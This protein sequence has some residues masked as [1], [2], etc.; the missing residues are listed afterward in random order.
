M[1]RLTLLLL[2]AAL[3]SHAH[4]ERDVGISPWGATDEIGQLNT[5][6]ARQRAA[7][8][9]RLTSQRIYD[10]SVDYYIGMPSWQAAGDPHYRLWMTHTPDG[11]VIDDPLEQGERKNRQVSY[12]GSAIS[13][14]SH[15]G[16]HIDALSHFGLNGKIWNGFSAAKYLGDRGWQRGGVEKFPPIIARG[17]MLDIAALHQQAMLPDGY[18]ITKDD[19]VASLARQGLQLH[20]GDVVLL[21]TGRMQRY[22]RAAAYMDSPPGLGLEA[23]KYLAEDAGVMVVGADNLSLEAFPSELDSD[24]VPVHTYLLAQRGVPIIEL[25]YLEE[26]A[27]DRVYEFAFIAAGLRLRGADAAPL[28]PIAIPL[29]PQTKEP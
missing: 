5:M 26:L 20:P 13:M 7:I 21:R 10:L 8:F 2:F 3:L 11:N 27:K 28:R 9:M 19:I 6:N 4:A 24:Y 23:A 25:A 15:T 17:V 29:L 1:K 22:E 16:T 14:Y 18:R 12:S